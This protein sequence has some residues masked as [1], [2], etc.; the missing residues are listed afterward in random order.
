MESGKQQ[1]LDAIEAEA[2]QK[3]AE[4]RSGAESAVKENTARAERELQAYLDDCASRD[5]ADAADFIARR[6][7]AAG[8]DGKKAVLA[9]KR[10]LLDAVKARFVERLYGLA[11]EDYLR[12]ITLL[13]EQYA[14]EG[15]KVFIAR[16]CAVTF[17]D[18][19]ALDVCRKK[20]LKVDYDPAVRSGLMLSGQKVDKDLSFEALADGVFADHEMELA[21]RLFGK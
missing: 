2:A 12:L 1:L 11:K 16:D 21:V 14:A 7:V 9:A 19:Q 3:V 6:K 17:G 5:A 10:A 13:L 4:I 18:V 8:M 20:A 15:D